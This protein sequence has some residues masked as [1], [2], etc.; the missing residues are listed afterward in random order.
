ML[1]ASCWVCPERFRAKGGEGGCQ[2]DRYDFKNRSYSRSTLPNFTTS[3]GVNFG[4]WAL[5]ELC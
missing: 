1:Q 3:T 4:E 2:R 5:G